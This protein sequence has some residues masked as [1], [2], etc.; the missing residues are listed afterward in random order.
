MHALFGILNLVVLTIPFSFA[1]LR[2]DPNHGRR[3]GGRRGPEDVLDLAALQD[4]PLDEG[5]PLEALLEAEYEG[6][7]GDLGYEEPTLLA[8]RLK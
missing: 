3:L 5:S 6:Y 7:D 2:E 4:H 1:S 8:A